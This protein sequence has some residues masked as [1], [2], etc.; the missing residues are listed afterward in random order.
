[1]TRARGNTDF[2][3]EN[4]YEK[5]SESCYRAIRSMIVEMKLLPG[6][7]IDKSVLCR[8]MNVS[9]QP[10]TTALSQLER[11]GLVEVLPQRGSYV[12]RL[13]RKAIAESLGIRAALESYATRRMAERATEVDLARLDAIVA[14]LD[15]ALQNHDETKYVAANHAFHLA[16]AGS[17]G[18]GKLVTQVDIGLAMTARAA[19]MMPS[20][21]W[22][23][24]AFQEH[25]R[26]IVSA[27]RR[28][29]GAI[30]SEVAAAHIDTL[31]EA[32]LRYS[33]ERPEYFVD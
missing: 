9:R 15:E 26:D 16:I 1:M 27:L 5:K 14:D 28:H 32:L 31:G 17:S 11:E 22:L 12:T 21:I 18:F 25:H 33:V 29:D 10:V 19:R 6:S 8:E 4:R 3:Q 2:I 20:D 30:A 24:Q 7:F 23:N 13:S